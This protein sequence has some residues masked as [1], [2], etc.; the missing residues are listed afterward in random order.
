MVKQTETSILNTKNKVKSTWGI[1]FEKTNPQSN[2]DKHVL[3][4]NCNRE[5]D[6]WKRHT[7]KNLTLK[8]VL[9]GKIFFCA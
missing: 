4:I 6:L 8:H 2:F 1:Q 5:E 7:A 9:R 3:D